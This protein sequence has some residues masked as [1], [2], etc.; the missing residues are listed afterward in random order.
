M[1]SDHIVCKNC[2][3][4]GYGTGNGFTTWCPKCQLNSGISRIPHPDRFV[5][6][7]LHGKDMIRNDH[8]GMKIVTESACDGE[9]VRVTIYRGEQNRPVSSEL[10]GVYDEQ[11]V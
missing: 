9:A 10:Y 5:N 8:Y 11:S 7:N 1:K 2:H 4:T 6:G 3:Y